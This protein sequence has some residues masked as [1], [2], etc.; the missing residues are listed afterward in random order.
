MAPTLAE[1]AKE[2]ELGKSDFFFFF[3]L[4]GKYDLVERK[5]YP[6]I[7][8]LFSVVFSVDFIILSLIT[9]SINTWEW[10]RLNEFCPSE[11][12]VLN[13]ALFLSYI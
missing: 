7:L 8:Q 3:S 9:R 2:N 1:L 13:Y 4:F 12:K 6:T 5:I 10:V 11:Y